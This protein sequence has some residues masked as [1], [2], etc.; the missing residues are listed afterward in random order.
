MD[1]FRNAMKNQN[2]RNENGIYVVCYNTARDDSKLYQ[3][4]VISQ[5]FNFD[6][7]QLKFLLWDDIDMKLIDRFNDDTHI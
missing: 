3:L 1:I 6:I 5:L 2:G 4:L 7:S